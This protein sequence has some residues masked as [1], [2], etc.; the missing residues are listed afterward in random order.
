MRYKHVWIDC[1]WGISACAGYKAYAGRRSMHGGS[2]I[3]PAARIEDACPVLLG[4]SYATNHHDASD[5]PTAQYVGATYPH[6][7]ITK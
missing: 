2:Y 5:S 1:W 6:C 3:L 7:D 4:L